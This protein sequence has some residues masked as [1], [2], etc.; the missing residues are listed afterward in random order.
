MSDQ[1]LP[2][3]LREI[4]HYGTFSRYSVYG[5]AILAAADELE[6]LRAAVECIRDS[7]SATAAEQ[8]SP[9]KSGSPW[10]PRLHL[11]EFL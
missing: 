1:E 3:L 6:R 2:A 7:D 10:L 4:I 9:N 11:G 8:A 5:E